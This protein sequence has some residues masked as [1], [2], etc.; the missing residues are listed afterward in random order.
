[1]ATGLR[2][3]APNHEGESRIERHRQRA[4][5]ARERAKRSLTERRSLARTRVGSARRKQSLAASRGRRRAKV[6]AVLRKRSV[7]ATRRKA[8]R[9]RARSK[10]ASE[11]ARS[12]V[13]ARHSG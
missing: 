3:E 1:M 11:R 9:A 10:R 7:A 6:A 12:R 8:E 2:N 4:A 13:G 5:N